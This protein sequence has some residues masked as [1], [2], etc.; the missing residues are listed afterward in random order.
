VKSG[1]WKHLKSGRLYL[2]LGTGHD[3]NDHSR[4]IVVYVPLYLGGAGPRL[5]VR[6][7]ADFDE[8]FEFMGEGYSPGMEGP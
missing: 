1:I 8:K 6:T 5:A 2:V 7:R 4:E 3:S